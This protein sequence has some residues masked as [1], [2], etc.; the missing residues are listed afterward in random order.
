MRIKDEYKGK[1]IVKYNSIMGEQRII[2]DKLDVTRFSYYQSIGLGYI[3][4]PEPINYIGI[5]EEPKQEPRKRRK[6]NG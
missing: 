3:F 5:D 6:K 1:T 2:V 4:E